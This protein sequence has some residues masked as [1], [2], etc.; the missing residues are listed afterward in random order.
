MR[1]Y[2]HTAPIV[3][4]VFASLLY[5]TAVTAQAQSDEALNAYRQGDYAS[6]VTK[7]KQRPDAAMRLPPTILPLCTCADAGS[8]RTTHAP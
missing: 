6:A 8:N 5:N 2:R 4:A 1:I 3:A 7:F